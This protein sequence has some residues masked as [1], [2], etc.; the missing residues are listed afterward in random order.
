M[1][2]KITIGA[3][4][5]SILATVLFY[6]FCLNHVNINEVGVAFNSGNGQLSLQTNAGWYVTSPLV[7]VVTLPT[8]PEAVHLPT[9][10][11][12]IA[13]KIVKIRPEKAIEFVKFQGFSYDIH[14]NWNNILMGYAFAGKP[15]DFLEVVQDSTEAL[16][17]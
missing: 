17:K 15:Y 9:T 2:L 7:K 1:K 4:I 6:I 13:T 3:V 10:A 12:V 16:N 8:L 11:N 5:L 14:A